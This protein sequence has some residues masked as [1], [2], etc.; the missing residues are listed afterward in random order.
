MADPNSWNEFK[1]LTSRVCVF[2][3]IT[4]RTLNLS[5]TYTCQLYRNTSFG[6][7]LTRL[8]IAPPRR[9]SV[10]S[11]LAWIYIWELVGL[12]SINIVTWAHRHESGPQHR[13]QLHD[14]FW[15][16][17]DPVVRSPLFIHVAA[18]S[19][20]SSTS[21]CFTLKSHTRIRWMDCSVPYR[22]PDSAYNDVTNTMTS[23]VIRDHFVFG[24]M[25]M[26]IIGE[27]YLFADE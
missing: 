2:T 12:G 14:L 25:C 7:L 18:M 8:Y 5:Y 11:L 20:L 13:N 27:V 9:T 15:T 16:Q 4:C 21:W 22:L 6:L 24:E 26:H 10:L 17:A 3:A 19:I 1:L 23:P